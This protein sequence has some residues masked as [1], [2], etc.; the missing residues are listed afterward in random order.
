MQYAVWT[1]S[2]PYER[3]FPTIA[4]AMAAAGKDI[5]ISNHQAVEMEAL[6]NQ[7]RAARMSYGFSGIEIT[8]KHE[9]EKI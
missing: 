7:G 2:K 1:S 3:T 4:A 8:P 9:G 5:Y 6:L